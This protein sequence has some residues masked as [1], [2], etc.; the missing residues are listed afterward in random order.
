MQYDPE[1]RSKSMFSVKD[2]FRCTM[3]ST[4][5]TCFSFN[6]L[7]VCVQAGSEIN[8][9]SGLSWKALIGHRDS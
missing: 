3:R 5:T 6:C 1:M 9:C 4:V 2:V 7:E 8:L